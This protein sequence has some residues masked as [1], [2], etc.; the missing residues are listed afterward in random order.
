MGTLKIEKASSGALER[1]LTL[2]ELA[3]HFRADVA[4]ASDTPQR[5]QDEEA[6][7]TCLILSLGKD[8]HVLYRGDAER[9]VR[10]EYEGDK[11]YRQ[12]IALQAPVAV[13]VERSPASGRLITLHLF[14]ILKDGRKPPSADIAA[15]LGGDLE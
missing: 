14:N 15:T 8:H 7:P 11:T 9:L 10:L 13:E 4:N 6:G 12:E 2:R 3:D 5:W 1:L